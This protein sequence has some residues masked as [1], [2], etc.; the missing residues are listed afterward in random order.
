MTVE[1]DDQEFD[2]T[3]R[4]QD[5]GVTGGGVDNGLCGDCDGERRRQ[6]DTDDHYATC[7]D[8]P[9]YVKV[10]PATFTGAPVAECSRC[11]FLSVYWDCPCDLIHK[12]FTDLWVCRDCYQEHHYGMETERTDG[13]SIDDN[14]RPWQLTDNTCPDHN[15]TDEERCDHCRETGYENGMMEFSKSPCDGCGSH[16]HGERNRFAYWPKG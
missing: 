16:L 8:W 2:N 1:T 6:S 3:H 14:Y 5:C 10:R 13:L 15:G 11:E 4:C 9:P 12:C 7:T